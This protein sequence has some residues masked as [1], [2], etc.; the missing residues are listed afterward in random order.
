MRIGSEQQPVR[1]TAQQERSG[2]VSAEE[3]IRAEN[4]DTEGQKSD[5][6]APIDSVELSKRGLSS[7]EDDDLLDLESEAEIIGK[8]VNQ[9][10]LDGKLTLPLI[11]LLKA[12][13]PEVKEKV[14][15]VVKEKRFEALS[16][17]ELRAL[18]KDYGVFESTRETVS[19]FCQQATIQLEAFT[20]DTPFRQAMLTLPQ[21]IANR[22]K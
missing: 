11:C 10:V 8:P 21:I 7:A 9:D 4:K 13:A 12:C 17:E 20:N 15:R 19:Q 16:R 3:Q 1:P 18:L 22:R 6:F 14:G 2:I 5:P